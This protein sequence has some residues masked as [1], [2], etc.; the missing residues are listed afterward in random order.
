[1]FLYHTFVQ[2]CIVLIF[3]YTYLHVDKIHFELLV[4]LVV[5][6]P[7]YNSEGRGF[8]LLKYLCDKQYLFLNILVGLSVSRLP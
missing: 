7:N 8:D 4:S 5:R 3:I 1:M 2:Y 6:A